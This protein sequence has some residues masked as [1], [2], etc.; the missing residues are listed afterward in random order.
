[1]QYSLVLAALVAAVQASPLAMPQ[2]VTAIITPSGSAPAGC[3]PAFSG[4]FGIMAKNITAPT[5]T[6]APAKRE[7]SPD[8]VMAHIAQINDGQIQGGYHTVT[9]APISQIGDGQPQAPV[10]VMP[11]SQSSDGQPE[12]PTATPTVTV[13][14]VSQSSDGQPE[15]TTATP[16]V[17]AP[18]VTESSEGQ[19]EQA[20]STASTAAP[21]S[22]GPVLAACKTNG[23]L[24]LVLNDG[25]LKDQNG[26]TGYIASNYQF[27]FD[28]PPQAGAIITAGFSVCGNGS[29]ALGGTN[30]F[31][32]C[33]S[34]SFYNLYDRNWAP[35]C[36][37]VTIETLMLI[38]CSAS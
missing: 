10:T 27:Q 22:T 35:Q 25:I 9:M 21:T 18:V 2:A 36:S 14:P 26:R 13:A 4:T 30:V 5:P 24:D 7:A 29:L 33:L 11:I 23:T 8:M 19:P 20:T 3:T 32:Q 37:P 28:D 17:T 12:G 16:T 31:W 6:A 15:A 34:G 38:D 1:M